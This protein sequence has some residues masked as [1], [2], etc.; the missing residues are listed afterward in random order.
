M[1]DGIFKLEPCQILFAIFSKSPVRSSARKHQPVEPSLHEHARKL[2]P[3]ATL[4]F[5]GQMEYILD[6]TRGQL[7]T[8]STQLKNN[9]PHESSSERE[10]RR[11]IGSP[12]DRG[13]I[14]DCRERR[15]RGQ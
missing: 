14:T 7:L 2:D 4:R 8:T 15:N 1:S 12:E 11:D 5:R 3:R 10:R 13:L 9:S 6:M